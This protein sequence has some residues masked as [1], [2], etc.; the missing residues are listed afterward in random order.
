[1][2]I[3]MAKSMDALGFHCMILSSN[4]EPPSS[5]ANQSLSLILSGEKPTYF[6]I[7]IF[8]HH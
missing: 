7:V 5:N 8:N 3:C 2:Y 6:Y 4:A 1:M